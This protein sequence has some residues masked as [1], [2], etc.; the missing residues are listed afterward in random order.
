MANSGLLGQPLRAGSTGGAWRGG[1]EKRKRCLS[2]MDATIGLGT[3]YKWPPLNAIPIWDATWAWDSSQSEASLG[4]TQGEAVSELLPS[5]MLSSLAFEISNQLIASP[6]PSERNNQ[7]GLDGA[8]LQSFYSLS[9]SHSA[10]HRV[11]VGL[12]TKQSSRSAAFRWQCNKWKKTNRFTKCSARADWRQSISRVATI[13]ALSFG[14]EIPKLQ[15]ACGNSIC[16]V[17]IFSSKV[18]L[19]RQA[20]SFDLYGP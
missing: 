11:L 10:G 19:T 14:F 18:K 16:L 15:E 6:L 17:E 20:N 8:F 12:E 5:R 3:A 13:W 4:A 2:W 7:C 9:P 1:G